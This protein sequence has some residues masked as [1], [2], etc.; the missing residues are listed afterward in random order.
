MT[1]GED[2]EICNI[3]TENK[4]NI[5][6][7]LP[8]YNEIENIGT[9]IEK[10]CKEVADYDYELIVVDDDSPDGTWK[11]V[12]QIS[13]HNHAVRIIRR[14][15]ERGLTSAINE[16]IRNAKGD[17]I[18]WMDCDLSM[19]PEIIPYLIKEIQE[20]GYDIS[21]GSRYVKGGGLVITRGGPDSI[22]SA[23][24][25]SILNYCIKFLFNHDFNDYTSGFVVARKGVFDIIQ[26][27]GDYGEYFIDFIFRA[28]NNGF[29]VA[30]VPYICQ[31]RIYGKSKT[32]TDIF[33]YIRKGIKYFFVVIRLL[34]LKYTKKL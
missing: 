31:P 11:K 15:R 25:S 29:K 26:L 17:M 1:F 23:F 30:E 6:V 19:P 24:L 32:G 13:E 4:V 21:V 7:V 34:I 3:D 10:I 20:N 5:S 14:I 28:I 8:T 16:G 9:L 27:S 12:V 22:M 33:D 2:V 18:L